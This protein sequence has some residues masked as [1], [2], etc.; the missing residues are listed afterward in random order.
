MKQ[1][2]ALAFAAALAAPAAQAQS[3]VIAARSFIRFALTQMGISVEGRFRKFDATIAF[4][5][6]K[7]EATKG[8]FT[9]E[10]ASIDLGTPESEAEARRK[11]WLDVQGFPQAR[12][13][14]ASVKALGGNR[15]EAR[16]PLTIKGTTRDIVAPF[17][18]SDANGVRVVD[19]QFT[20]KR[21]QYKVGEGEW[22]DTDTV[23]DDIAVHFRFAIP[24]NGAPP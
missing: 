5:P 6:A 16:G 9:V 15:F 7:P 14:A 19:G 13:T 22:A 11:P 17:T 4:D 12:F 3:N 8:E 18:V 23:A 20:L 24:L 1:L 21:L 10:L 2:A